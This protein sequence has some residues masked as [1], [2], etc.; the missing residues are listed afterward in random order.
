MMKTKAPNGHP[1]TH[2]PLDD[3][4]PVDSSILAWWHAKTLVDLSKSIKPVWLKLIL[5]TFQ[6][7]GWLATINK[8]VAEQTKVRYSSSSDFRS[9]GAERCAVSSFPRSVD[10][11]SG[12]LCSERVIFY[13][14]R[15]LC[16]TCWLLPEK[17]RWKE[18][19][20]CLSC[21]CSKIYAAYAHSF[22]ALALAMSAAVRQDRTRKR[23][24]LLS[25]AKKKLKARYRFKV[26]KEVFPKI[27]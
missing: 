19:S 17:L 15:M 12:S 26:E 18:F 5:K 3:A 16:D 21:S 22:S 11:P 20:I 2:P 9:K 25:H 14:P 23:I 27:K 6:K 8:K 13:L 24:G 4:A 1:C 10:K 7:V